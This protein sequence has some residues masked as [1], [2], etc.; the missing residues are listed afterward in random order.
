L[1]TLPILF[2]CENNRYA[3]HTHQSRRQGNLDVCAKAR[4]F[5]VPAETIDG[6]D[7]DTLVRRAQQVVAEIRA[8]QGPRFLEVLTYRLKEHVGPNTDYHLGYRTEEE[9][10]VWLENDAV[11]RI[12]KLVEPRER[13]CIEDEVE[14]EIEDAFGF[15]EASPWPEAIELTRDVYQEV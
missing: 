2:V 10:N 9:A 13:A 14:E 8:G 12:G 15:A 3:I 1:K 4:A 7:L 5:G 6:N 11:E